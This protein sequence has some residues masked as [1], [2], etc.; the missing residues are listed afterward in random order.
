MVPGLKHTCHKVQKDIWILYN[1]TSAATLTLT[2]SKP[3][4]PFRVAITLSPKTDHVACAGIVTIGGEA[5]SF[6]AAGRKT[7]T[8]SLTA[9]PVV[10]TTGLDCHILLEAI[11]ISGQS[12]YVETLT[13][14]KCR[15]TSKQKLIPKPEGGFTLTSAEVLT[16]V[17]SCNGGDTLRYLGVDYS[18][19]EVDPKSKLSGVEFLRRLYVV[20]G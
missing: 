4:V 11:T 19:Q 13:A 18:I 5:I 7:T 17:A 16:Q 10:T 1:N 12:I 6:S 15:W 8:N 14:V 9:L 3:I 2:G 20:R